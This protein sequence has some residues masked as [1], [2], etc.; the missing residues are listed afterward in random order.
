MFGSFLGMLIMAIVLNAFNILGVDI[1]WQRLI[2][3]LILLAAVLGD[4]LRK[5]K[6]E[7]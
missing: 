7:G 4:V 1:Y 2:L 5:R 6:L 3:G